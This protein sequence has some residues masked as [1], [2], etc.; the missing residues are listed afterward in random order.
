MSSIED[1]VDDETISES[2]PLPYEVDDFNDPTPV[3]ADSFSEWFVEI[4]PY[5]VDD[6]YPAPSL[7]Q[8]THALREK[9]LLLISGEISDKRSLARRTAWEFA[10]TL[11]DLENT[12]V[13]AVE[14]RYSTPANYLLQALDN[15]TQPT[16]FVFSDTEPYEFGGNLQRVF[17]ATRQK[18]YVILTTERPRDAWLLHDETTPCWIE[19]DR[20]KLYRPGQLDRYLTLL[21]KTQLDGIAQKIVDEKGDELVTR[22]LAVL[23][24]SPE[25]IDMFIQQY[26]RWIELEVSKR[27]DIALLINEAKT[28]PVVLDNWFNH[29]LNDREQ[30]VAIAMALVAGLDEEAAFEIIEHL[31]ERVWQRR[32]ASFAFID[33]GDLINLRR[34]ILF[35]NDTTGTARI[36]LKGADSRYHILKAAWPTRR[37]QILAAVGALVSFARESLVSSND[38]FSFSQRSRVR[39]EFTKLTAEALGDTARLSL[40][41]VEPLLLTLVSDDRIETFEMM[42]DALGQ[43]RD[44]AQSERVYKLLRV[45][46][47]HGELHRY[48][49]RLLDKKDSENI[50]Q[51]IGS[52]VAVAVGKLALYDK[53]N[54]MNEEV[55]QL[56]KSYCKSERLRVIKTISKHALPQL[57]PVHWLQMKELVS[58]LLNRVGNDM[59]LAQPLVEGI[60]RGL[61]NAMLVQRLELVSLVKGWIKGGLLSPQHKLDVKRI[62][63]REKQLGAALYALS[64]ARSISVNLE[65]STSARA[66]VYELE[67]PRID[68]ES[69]F[70]DTQLSPGEAAEMVAR[71]L[72]SEKH[73]FVRKAALEAIQRLLAYE[74]KAILVPFEKLLAKLD[75]GERKSIIDFL[76]VHHRCQRSQLKGGDSIIKVGKVRIPVWFDKEPPDTEILEQVFTW[77]ADAPEQRLAAFAGEVVYSIRGDLERTEEQELKR[78]REQRKQALADSAKREEESVTVTIGHQLTVSFLQKFLVIPLATLGKPQLKEPVTGQL[79]VAAHRS[80]AEQQELIERFRVANKDDLASGLSRA[81]WINNLRYPIAVIIIIALLLLLIQFL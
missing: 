41:A 80:E 52:A 48:L 27:P 2:E 29:Q 42:A 6:E 9:R 12:S 21:I 59:Q 35:Q 37:R 71:V 5:S 36:L 55:V 58:D 77:A 63:I 64:Y 39:S 62:D 49:A 28:P 14:A 22:D 31:M 54:Q 45:W 44:S 32:D 4:A 18:H 7:G 69:H 43:M 26:K 10:Q 68:D 79:V 50:D 76:V 11:I 34:H 75:P 74:F 67:I 24:E 60:G 15:N 38:N 56:L 73:P 20:S 16:V 3:N 70:S 8:L 40:D 53:P 78:L 13:V 72:E 19:Q 66:G 61:G 81:L 57:I 51:T 17:R 25:S 23:L 46:R 47:G 30:S 65:N 33:Y 1:I